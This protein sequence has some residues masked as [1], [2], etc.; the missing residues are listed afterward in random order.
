MG[1]A[2]GWMGLMLDLCPGETLGKRSFV[3]SLCSDPAALWPG[4]VL[5]P[6]AAIKETCLTLSIGFPT[7]V[8]S[9]PSVWSSE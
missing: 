4:L 8:E 3:S 1:T 5:G 6:P 7:A 2:P 9:G